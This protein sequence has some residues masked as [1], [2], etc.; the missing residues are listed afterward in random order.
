MIFVL[1]VLKVTI[2]QVQFISTRTEEVIFK[3]AVFS[4]RSSLFLF[5]V[6]E[7]INSGKSKNVFLFK[8]MQYAFEL[9]RKAKER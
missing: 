3:W 7:K 4:V 5:K 6:L 8:F 1:N 2:F 9:V